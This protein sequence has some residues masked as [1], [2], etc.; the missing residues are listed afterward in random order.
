MRFVVDVAFP[1]IP[2]SQPLTF[3]EDIYWAYCVSPMCILGH[4]WVS[5]KI[6]PERDSSLLIF[7][8]PKDFQVCVYLFLLLLVYTNTTI[9]S[10]FATEYST[11]KLY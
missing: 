11:Q 3:P 10:K 4:L 9:H 2:F 5:P 8:A 6:F 7:Q 1:H